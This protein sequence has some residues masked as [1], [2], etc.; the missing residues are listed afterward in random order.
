[1][2]LFHSSVSCCFMCVCSCMI[3]ERIMQS[4]GW[5]EIFWLL[6]IIYFTAG[7]TSVHRDLCSTFMRLNF[8]LQ[9]CSMYCPST[10]HKVTNLCRPT[11]IHSHAS[12]L[13]SGLMR[14]VTFRNARRLAKETNHVNHSPARK[15]PS[16][17]NE[18]HTIHKGGRMKMVTQKWLLESYYSILTGAK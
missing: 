17:H 6:N 8:K 1:M 15:Q 12:R 7:S 2:I 18:E 10:A 16:T 5:T 13:G 9:L 11:H 4:Y 3:F 14:A